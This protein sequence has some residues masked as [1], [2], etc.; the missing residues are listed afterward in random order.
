MG[1]SVKD[2]TPS[3]PPSLP[4]NVPISPQT[5]PAYAFLAT[6]VRDTG[7]VKRNRDL[8]HLAVTNCPESVTYGLNYLHALELTGEVKEAWEFGR[9]FIGRLKGMGGLGKFKLNEGRWGG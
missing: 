8:L 9:E 1:A 3:L 5:A 6:I 7:H 2:L 4:S